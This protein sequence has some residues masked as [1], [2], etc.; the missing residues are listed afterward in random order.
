MLEPRLKP[1]VLDDVYAAA[2]RIGAHAVRTPLL[3]SEALN[4]RFGARILFKPEC[5]QRT[6]SFKFRGAFNKLASLGED[7]RRRGVVAFSSGNHAQGVAAAAR[8]HGAPAVN[9]MPSDAPKMKIDN[10]RAYGAEVILYDRW[11]EDRV[12][13]ARRV[14]AER[15]MALVPPF[16]DPFVI[17]GQGTIGLE[18]IEQAAERGAQLDMVVSPCG[19]GGLIGGIATAVK[20]L[21]PQTDVWA[22]EPADFD[23]TRRSLLAGR[24]VKNEPGRSSICDALLAEQPGELTFAINEKYLAGAIA[25]RES[26]T[27]QAMR[28]IAKA[29]KLV[30][31][32]GGAVAFAALGSPELDVRGKTVAV[33]L[34]GGNV[35]PEAY[36]RWLSAN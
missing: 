13:I 1:V 19:G 30:V 18:L 3:E 7:E 32:P 27:V 22:A 11:T 34:S 10:T 5:L 15:G 36:A 26:E 35:D 8:L 29:L 9:V 2:S 28:D 16:D 23:D 33:I 17:A 6:G 12:E 20:G 21:S 24:R 25:V 4:E 31:E 14:S